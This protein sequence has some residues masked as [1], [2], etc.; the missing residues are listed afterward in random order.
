MLNGTLML[1]ARPGLTR[2]PLPRTIVTVIA[3]LATLP[4]MLERPQT[5]DA[6]PGFNWAL[7]TGPANNL[8]E[9][10]TYGNGLFV[11]VSSNGTSR[12]MT[13]P[14]GINWTL[15]SSPAP[16]QWWSVTY[17]NGLFVAVAQSGTGNRV[18][19][20]PDG[21]NWTI[22]SSAADNNWTSVTYG[23]GLFV[24]VAQSGT[25]NRV[26]TSP[27]GINWT[28]RSSAADNDWNSVTYG[29]GLF[30]AVAKTGTGNRVMTSLDGITWTARTSAADNDW[31]SVTYASGLFVAVAWTGTGNRVMTSPDGINWTIRS[32]AADEEW[33]SVTH[34]NNLFVAVSSTGP[35]RVMTSPD[36]I[37]WTLRSSP[38]MLWRSVAYANGMFVA[39]STGTEVMTS[40]AYV[41]DPPDPPTL[42]ATNP[43]SPANDNS[44]E[45][46]GTA[47]SGSTVRLYTTPDCTGAPA[48]TGTAATFAAAGLTATVSDNTS[49]TFRATAAD[50]A[51]NTSA[52][53]SSSITYI[54]DST[55]PAAPTLTATIPPSPANDNSPEIAGTA[56]SGSTVRLYTTPDC[57]GAPAA[58]GTAATFAAAGLTATVSD[59]TSTTFRATAT[60]GA[61]NTSTCSTG[62]AYTEDST[63]PVIPGPEP[64]NG[65]SAVVAPVSGVIRIK[66]PGRGYE[67]L[68]SLKEIPVGS[69]VDATRGG[70]RLEAETAGGPDDNQ[71]AVFRGGVFRFL[72]PE[73][74]TQVTLVLAGGNN[75]VCRA[76]GKK[77]DR[78]SSALYS[79]GWTT[80]GARTSSARVVR[81][82]W[83]K[84]SG[85]FKTKG[86]GGAA[87]VRGT[88]W[89][90]QDRCD[91]TFFRVTEGVVQVDDFAKQ[92]VVTLRP[93]D[94]YLARVK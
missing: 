20:S 28:L 82:L 91:G 55:Q 60:D 44:P 6:S 3:I 50:A 65:E 4:A 22:Q 49:T 34:G 24:A 86:R 8:W 94:R 90:T 14:D 63:P 15:R 33:N 25:G 76:A 62:L 78:A 47:E 17:G 21:I 69:L 5:A 93:G 41:A 31:W 85:R 80:S 52:C 75:R 13:S 57:T 59:N 68:S 38:A 11:A 92:R 46:A 67:S 54:E 48:A 88:R 70:V 43:P 79:L 26:M 61:N 84:G 23:N 53:S 89:L 18:M 51:D 72:Q 81:S 16:N 66:V 87:T 40:G 74:R 83:G 37:N 45:I 73:G 77:R 35:E 56:E 12:V 64:V 2:Q 1:P 7:D 29:N 32:S 27:D 10:V 42:T 36:G 9:S 71:S 30:A 19:T 39:V 58:T